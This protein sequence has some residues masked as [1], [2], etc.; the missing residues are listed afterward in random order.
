MI[1]VK[2]IPAHISSEMALI[3]SQGHFSLQQTLN[4]LKLQTSFLWIKGSNNCHFFSPRPAWL[5]WPRY[6][7]KNK[8]KGWNVRFKLGLT[9]QLYWAWCDTRLW[10]SY[11]WLTSFAPSDKASEPAAQRER[12]AERERERERE[13]ESRGCLA[14]ASKGLL[15]E[16]HTNPTN[17]GK[18][19]RSNYSKQPTHN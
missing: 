10:I 13:R 14:T 18:A 2:V 5:L 7:N 15:G 9:A 12:R 11:S 4:H 19:R 6:P 3:H 16:G 1:K 8:Q 17:G